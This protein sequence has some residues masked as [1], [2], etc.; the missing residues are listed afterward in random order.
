MSG[1]PLIATHVGGIPEIF[2]SSAPDLIPP[3]DTKALSRA[4]A[5]ILDEPPE[6]R[7]ARFAALSASVK[8][9]FSMKRMGANVLSGYAAAFAAREPA[10]ASPL[11]Q[12][13]AAASKSA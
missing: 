12:P 11:R 8:V 1:K 2:G 6:L 5:G 9:R 13:V 3:R 7:D 4:I 10:G